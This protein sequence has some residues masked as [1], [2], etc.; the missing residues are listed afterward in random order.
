MTGQPLGRTALQ[1]F[2]TVN[3]RR[4]LLFLTKEAGSR[5]SPDSFNLG[6]GRWE[7]RFNLGR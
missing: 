5:V 7:S 1:E 6:F 4:R 3:P 2:A